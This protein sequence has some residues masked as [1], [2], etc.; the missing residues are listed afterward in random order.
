MT[1]YMN[2]MDINDF[3]EK[4]ESEYTKKICR[5]ALNVWSRKEQFMKD[6][7]VICSRQVKLRLH[8]QTRNRES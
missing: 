1:E 7:F 5:N 3:E 4:N 2:E 8:L 6:T